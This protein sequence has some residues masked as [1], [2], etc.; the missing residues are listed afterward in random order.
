MKA[1]DYST[2]NCYF[3]TIC[4][5][6]KRHLFG[7]AGRLNPLGEIAQEAIYQ[8]PDHFPQTAV[9][10]A[11]VMPNHVHMMLVLQDNSANVSAIVG[12]YKS[13]VSRRIR[14]IQ[15]VEKIWQNSFHDH[16]IRDQQSYEKIWLYIHANPDNWEKDC[17]YSEKQT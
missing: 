17:F 5:W 14:Q 2:P 8:I 12:Q 1:Y 7:E 15:P 10:K 6:S 3:I 13:Y 16:V 9:D 4:T 11:V